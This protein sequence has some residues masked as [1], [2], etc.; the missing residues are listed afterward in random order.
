MRVFPT[1]H[2][3]LTTFTHGRLRMNHV[4]CL[5]V[6]HLGLGAQQLPLQRHP[7][8]T[9]DSIQWSNLTEALPWPTA[10]ILERMSYYEVITHPVATPLVSPPSYEPPIDPP[11][12]PRSARTAQPP[13]TL[14]AVLNPSTGTSPLNPRDVDAAR[15]RRLSGRP[16]PY[17]EI[18]MARA[19]SR[20]VTPVVRPPPSQQPSL[21]LSPE[22]LVNV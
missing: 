11:A 15:A 9:H 20:V 21:T 7:T 12:I 10:T 22:K 17:D 1:G 6:S 16:R 5:D 19:T 4:W 18:I 13:V 8:S 2:R 14:A 3:T